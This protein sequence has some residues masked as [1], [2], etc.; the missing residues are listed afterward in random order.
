MPKLLE[1]RDFASAGLNSDIL[2]WDLPPQFLTE[3][4]NV[5][6]IRNSL[7]PFGGYVVWSE[8]PAD[9]TPGALMHIGATSGTYWMIMGDTK[10]YVFDGIVYSD[11]TEP[12]YIPVTDPDLWTGAMLSRIP[13][14]NNPGAYPYYWSPQAGGNVLTILPW[15]ATQTWEDV[16]QSCDVMRSHKQFLFALKVKPTGGVGETIADGVRW[17]APADI[18]GVPNTWDELDTTD[19]A[20]LTTLGGDGG[21]IIDGLSLRDAFVVYRER[22]LSVFDYVGGQFV[23]Q[24][25]NVSTTVGL[26][27]SNC[28]VEVK[29]KHLFIGDGDVLVF[30]GN[31]IESLMH[32]RIRKHFISNFNV[33][34]YFNAFAVKNNVLNEVWFC[35]PGINSEYANMV[36]IYNWRDDTWSVRDLPE[37][38]AGDYG[39]YTSSS[40]TWEDVEGSWDSISSVWNLGGFSP[41]QDTIVVIEKPKG[42]AGGVACKIY[43]CD[44][45]GTAVSNIL[46]PRSHY[47]M[48]SLDEAP[49]GLVAGGRVLDAAGTNDLYIDSNG[50]YSTAS[51]MTDPCVGALS[52]GQESS[53]GEFFTM[54]STR[55]PLP[56]MVSNAQGLIGGV[57]KRTGDISASC[58]SVQFYGPND[59][60][61]SEVLFSAVTNT[62]TVDWSARTR[63]FTDGGVNDGG[64]NSGGNQLVPVPDSI[65]GPMCLQIGW[66][67]T[68]LGTTAST[69]FTLYSEWDYANPIDS[70][71]L[72]GEVNTIENMYVSSRL[73]LNSGF[74]AQNYMFVA[75][76]IPAPS[77]WA[78]MAD[79]WAQNQIGYT[80]PACE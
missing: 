62:G 31:S 41:L 40:P 43:E 33:E 48:V 21:D 42:G 38:V 53:N 49:S 11:I 51:I 3:V 63:Q 14:I 73:Q 66:V 55:P 6:I 67:T 13:V 4:N 60:Q 34:F 24:I 2:S 32:H 23:W 58:I 35:I 5:R 28:V 37:A 45:Y 12:T 75:D 15:D 54:S 78:Q 61:T 72:S 59:A 7:T 79:A 10:V 74:Q 27:A 1:I 9:F 29:G 46:Q 50:M 30:D 17:S 8:M 70:F 71:V 69:T 52:F 20:G 80:D 22:G 64:P 47:P 25:R 77:V 26:L 56:D 18:N 44:A 39:S 57:V 16:G 65:G 36:Y 68:G 19:V 76:T